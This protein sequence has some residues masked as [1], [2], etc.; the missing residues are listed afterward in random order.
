MAVAVA[1][2]DCAGCV[3]T[4]PPPPPRHFLPNVLDQVTLEDFDVVSFLDVDLHTA[5]QTREAVES[6]FKSAYGQIGHPR[7][8]FYSFDTDSLD[9]IVAHFE[10]NACARARY[11][12]QRRLRVK[13][14][15]EAELALG[16]T[17]VVSE[18]EVGTRGLKA[19]MTRREVLAIAGRA[20]TEYAAGTPGT[21]DLR[22]AAYC[23]RFVGGKVAHV[24]RPETCASF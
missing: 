10:P 17:F 8:F 4:A 13:R 14:T 2:L 20:Q 11:V 22:Y 1:A 19:G 9:F 6:E 15:K 7:W 5:V 23:V 12:A 21:F 16:V 18:Y 3:G 24:A